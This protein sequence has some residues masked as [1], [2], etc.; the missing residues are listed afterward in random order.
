VHT[1]EKRDTLSMNAIAMSI[2][3]DSFNY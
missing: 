2:T 3:I 1:L